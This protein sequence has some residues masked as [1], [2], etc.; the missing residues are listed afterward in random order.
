MGLHTLTGFASSKR[1]KWITLLLWIMLA[2][3]VV[4][5]APRLEEVRSNEDSIFLPGDAESAAAADLVSERFPDSGTPAII[6]LRNETGLTDADLD[7]A[8][9][10]NDYILSAQAG[11]NIDGVVSIFTV[12]QAEAELVSADGTTMTIIASLTGSP[13]EQPYADTVERI[14]DVTARYDNAELMVKVSGPGG[15][16]VDLVK[17]FEGID[18]FLLLVTAVLVLVLLVAIYRSPIVALVPLVCV[19]WVFTLANGVA[20]WAS[21]QIGFPVDGQSTGIMTVLLFGAGTDYCLFISSR[22]REELALVEDKHEAMR[23]SMRGVGGAIVSAGATILIA[24]VILLLAVLPAYRSLGPVLAIAVALMMAAALTLVP[25]ILTILGRWSFWPFRPKYNPHASRSER[26]G[27]VW[28]RIADVVLRRPVAVLSATVLL[29][30]AMT[31]GMFE[32]NP[33]YDSLESLPSDAESVEGFELLRAG[34]PAG[35]LAPTDVYVVLDEGQSAF[36]PEALAAIDAVTAELAGRPD[37]ASVNSPSRPFGAGVPPGPDALIAAIEGLPAEVRESL[38]QGSGPGGAAAE[39]DPV[40]PEAEAIG[41]Y[42]AA[43]QF[44]SADGGV[45]RVELVLEQ[46]P[47]GGAAL[48]LIPDLRAT[49]RD[50][51]AGAG[52]ARDSVLVGGTTAESYDTRAANNRDTVIV[53]PL[54]LLAIAIILGLLLRSLVAPLY[55]SLTIILSYFATLGLAILCF[56]YLFGQDTISS[57]VP[58]Y[59][60]VF[61]NALGVDYNI[62]LMARIR[63]ES[64]RFDLEEATRRALSRTGGVITS[65]GL[66]L[67]G[68]FSA[69]MTLPL[70][71][72]FQLGF[73]V[74]IGVLMDTFLIRTL[75]VPS[76]VKVL[77]RWNWWPSQALQ[78]SNPATRPSLATDD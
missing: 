15:L 70:Q 49:A 71:D 56:K 7:A 12:P 34:F 39:V 43:G 18:G 21:Q 77:G 19:G 10:I 28:S 67:A 11:E 54:I 55:L 74:A 29:L 59:L 44:V 69:L 17:V 45:A 58:F 30:L 22:F 2:A 68:T 23:R 66:I 62:Y 46:N 36:D 48:D 32:Y 60:F 24:T 57:S 63:E 61:L 37:V 6:V 78:R 25:A 35:E 65:A 27:P 51:A 42:A 16:V 75:M 72:L 1:G 13:G 41:L 8:R 5:L 33:T 20:A 26:A 38:D 53:L 50:A 14:R 64:Q 31:L 52:L 9:Q 73:A 47:Y 40:S 3:V 4:P 76:I